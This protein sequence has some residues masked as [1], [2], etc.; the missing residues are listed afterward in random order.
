MKSQGL[1]VDYI[2]VFDDVAQAIQKCLA[3]SSGIDRT[4]EGYEGLPAV[5]ECLPDKKTRDRFAADCSYLARLWEAISSDPVLSDHETDYRW[6]IEVYASVKPST[7]T[8]KLLWHN[9]GAKTIELIHQNVYV[10]A[11]QDD[12]ETQVLY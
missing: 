3:Y 11:V 8:G 9:L 1:I 4:L 2:G 5:Q 10:E 7:G 12:L 6:I